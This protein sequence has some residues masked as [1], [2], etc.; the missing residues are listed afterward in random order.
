MKR[1]LLLLTFFLTQLGF[2][3]TTIAYEIVTNA[4][5]FSDDEIYVGLVGQTSD[6]PVWIDFGTNAKDSPALVAIDESQNTV[7]K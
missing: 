7:H 2:S 5:H 6:G 1:T 4:P 3:Q